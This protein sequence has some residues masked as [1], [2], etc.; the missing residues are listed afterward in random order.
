MN[1]I[2]QTFEVLKTTKRINKIKFNLIGSFTSLCGI[3]KVKGGP[4]DLY[5]PTIVHILSF[6]I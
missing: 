1:L 4:W 3:D 2:D 6:I 5:S